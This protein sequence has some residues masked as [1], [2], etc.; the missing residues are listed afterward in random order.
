MHL[1]GIGGPRAPHVFEFDRRGNLG[2]FGKYFIDVLSFVFP[3]VFVKDILAQ[4]CQWSEIAWK[5]WILRGARLKVS[6]ILGESD[7][8]A[9]EGKF[10]QLAPHTND[11]ILRTQGDC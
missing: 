1:V 6:L 4:G 2:C 7:A 5:W 8:A 11:V 9:A 10:W 3:S